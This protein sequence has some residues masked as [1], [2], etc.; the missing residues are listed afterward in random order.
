MTADRLY[1]EAMKLPPR[2]KASLVERLVEDVGVHLDFR[3][4]R[5]PP[6]LLRV[7]LRAALCS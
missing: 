2:A 6:E 3:P 5:S 1:E 4:A 7:R